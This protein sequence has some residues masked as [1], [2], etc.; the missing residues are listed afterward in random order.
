METSASYL[1]FISGLA[2]GSSATDG[3]A[4]A[5]ERAIDFLVARGPGRAPQTDSISVTVR[6]VLVCGGTFCSGSNLAEKGG[7][8]AFAPAEP[9]TAVPSSQ[10]ISQ[11]LASAIA[12]ADTLFARLA[13][14]VP[15][16]VMPGREDPTN[17]SLPQMP[18]YRALFQRVQASRGALRFVTNPFA[19]DLEGTSLLGHAGQPL[20]D[21]A[22]CTDLAS[23]LDILELC[24]QA[25][26]LA[27]TAPDTLAAQPFDSFDPFV[28]DT[29]PHVFFSGGHSNASV[30]WRGAPPSGFAEQGTLCI[31]VPAFHL[32]RAIVLLNLSDR[33]DVRV[34]D[35]P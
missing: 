18:I 30:A 6:H 16:E 5:R 31:C 2:F 19:R 9:P 21:L 35:F 15:V 12:E 34:E 23:P 8:C 11:P 28:I 1:A 20:Q 3:F 10:S 25:R 17:P 24:L 29:R 22:R 4:A 7:G 27:P 14:A 13:A 32:Q 26:H 33:S